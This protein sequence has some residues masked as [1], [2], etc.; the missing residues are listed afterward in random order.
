MLYDGNNNMLHLVNA[1][2]LAW[3]PGNFDVKPRNVSAL[4][5]RIQG[6]ADMRCAGK[7]Y[8][9]AAGDILYL[10]QGLGYQVAY[11]E[12]E[13]LVIH[14]VTAADDRE[15]E[16]YTLQNRSR[17]HQLFLK[18]AELWRAKTPGYVNYCTAIFYEIMGEI[19]A[20]C[21]QMQMP[22][23]FKNAVDYIHQ[24]F[25]GQLGVGTICRKTAISATAF[26]Q[27]FRIYYGITPTE[28]IRNLRLEY[29]RN[30]LSGGMSV[31]QAAEACGIGDSKY[32]A[33]LVKEK[34]GCSPRNLKLHGK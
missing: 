9:I 32:F 21:M 31:E 23:H 14:F 3:Q 17:V 6:S 30:L 20:E 15:P 25:R 2:H 10:P 34:Y 11:T 33:R 28:Y 5:F 19:C 12:T 13:M 18:A 8:H 22:E 4:A 29:A 7:R 1:E 27:Y 26:R 16:V 24:N